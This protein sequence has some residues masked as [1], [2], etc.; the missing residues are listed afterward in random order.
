M[1]D[2]ANDFQNSLNHFGNY[3][4]RWHLEVNTSKTKV[5]VFGIRAI[6]NLSFKLCTQPLA[7]TD[8]YLDIAFSN[9]G[10][11]LRAR[12]HIAEQANKALHY[13]FMKV[14]NSDLPLDLV[15]K[16]FDHTVLPILTY[17]SEVF[18]FENIEI[19]EKVH[20]NF[21][22]KITGSRKSTPLSFLYGELGRYPIE[23]V[24]MSCMVSFWNRFLTG[25]SEK[26]SLKIHK[27]MLASPQHNFKW[28]KKIKEILITVGRPDLWENQFNINQGNLHKTIK[29]TLIDQFKENWHEQLSLSNEG[30]LFLNFKENHAF[31]EYLR[32]LNRNEYLPLLRF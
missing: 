4:N 32:I 6:N 20:S 9:N 17:G 24:I 1:S 27:Y 14:N 21:L 11:F 2:N 8:H 30:R 18:G 10:S 13:L 12:K 26:I 15:I 31:E 19:L 22:R 3:C 28:P 16:L 5:V 29:Q 25:K 23:I 7:I